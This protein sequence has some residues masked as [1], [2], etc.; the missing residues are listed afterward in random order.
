MED[1]C[2]ARS[3]NY[4]KYNIIF[5]I[6]L[7]FWAAVCIAN[8]CHETTFL[9]DEK[10]DTQQ[11]TETG[12]IKWRWNYWNSYRKIDVIL[13]HMPQKRFYRLKVFSKFYLKWKPEQ[14][15]L[16]GTIIISIST[17]INYQLEMKK[18]CDYIGNNH[19]ISQQYGQTYDLM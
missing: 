14:I 1:K 5:G 11:G 8:G 10:S 3:E 6:L 19:I 7:P 17:Y 13:R 4:G 12:A 16:S 9:V 18:H 2:T 15:R